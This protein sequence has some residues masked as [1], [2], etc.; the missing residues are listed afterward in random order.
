MLN[1]QNSII[2]W[3]VSQLGHLSKMLVPFIFDGVK[4][5]ILRFGRV[6]NRSPNSGGGC[7]GR[8]SFII[9][10]GKHQMP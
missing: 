6:G 1:I 2:V 10:F 9:V 8:L 5:N 3:V 4:E 7:R